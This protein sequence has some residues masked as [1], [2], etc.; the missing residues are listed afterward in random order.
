[1]IAILTMLETQDEVNQPALIPVAVSTAT[2][3]DSDDENESGGTK[4]L[5]HLTQGNK[6]LILIS[7]LKNPLILS[8]HHLPM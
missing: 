4:N 2:N 5:D 1:M 6:T 8:S 3:D 7:G